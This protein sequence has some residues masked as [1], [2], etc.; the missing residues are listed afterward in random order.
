MLTNLFRLTPLF[1]IIILTS[2]CVKESYHEDVGTIFHTNYRIKYKA[3]R[4]LAKEIEEELTLFDAS[5]NPFNKESII[6]KINNNQEVEVDKW[7][8]EV[9]NKAM[10]VSVNTG[11]AFDITCA[12]L[13]NL[14]GFGFS[15]AEEATPEKIDSIKTFVG[16]QKARIKEGKVEKDDDRLML[17]CSAIAKG[18]SCDVIA[19]LLERYGVKNYMVEIGGEV[20][21]K[22]HNPTGKCWRIGI[23]KPIEDVLGTVSEIQDIV[24]VCNGAVATSGNYRNFQVKDGK[25]YAHTINPHTGY[26]SQ[27][28]ILSA[29]IIANDCMTADAYATAFMVLGRAQAKKLAEKLTGEIEYYLI[30]VDNDRYAFDYSEG[31]A[32]Y[33]QK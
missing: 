2:S 24:S 7:F 21:M 15:K 32:Q 33:I 6:A 27:S 25:K 13:I 12:P 10:E 18:Y 3:P 5:L 23:N 30:Y 9:F 26:P 22:G 14:W 19:N 1:F 11:G 31:M 28:D 29:T 8:A 4:S 17:N 16:Y 20:K